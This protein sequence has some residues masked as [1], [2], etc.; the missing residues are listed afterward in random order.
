MKLERYQRK[1]C[2]SN[3]Y[4]IAVFYKGDNIGTRRIIFWCVENYDGI[5]S[6]YTIKSVPIAQAII[7]L[8]A[9]Y[10]QIELRINF[11]SLC[12]LFKRV[13]KSIKKS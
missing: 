12:L 6:Y 13:M 5:K 11:G 4:K 10:L 3:E 8:E 7:Y 2:I 9:C 1:D